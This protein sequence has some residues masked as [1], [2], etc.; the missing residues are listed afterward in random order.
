MTS[1][2]TGSIEQHYKM[3]VLHFKR[4]H[5]AQDVLAKIGHLPAG[6]TKFESKIFNGLKALKP[7]IAGGDPLMISAKMSAIESQLREYDE[8]IEQSN[9]T[10][11]P[12]GLRQYIQKKDLKRD[13]LVGLA[14]YLSNKQSDLPDDRGKL[15]L[16]LSELGKEM[17]REEEE[18]LLAELF[19]EPPQLTYAS[20]ELLDQLRALTSQLEAIKT[21]PQLI[22]GEYMARAR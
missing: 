7:L 10:L 3:L 15:E 12:Y 13:D 19:P 6:S 20:Q 17:G 22:D 16:I 4:L 8:W 5:G 14:R 21:F 11:T 1:A 2:P 9:N 18:Q